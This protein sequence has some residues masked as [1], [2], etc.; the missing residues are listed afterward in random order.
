MRTGSPS[1]SSRSNH[2]VLQDNPSKAN[3]PHRLSQCLPFSKT[4]PSLVDRQSTQSNSRLLPNASTAANK[5]DAN[6][7][8]TPEWSSYYS[9]SSR[10]T[11]DKPSWLSLKQD[12]PVSVPKTP[13]QSRE[14]CTTLRGAATRLVKDVPTR[15]LMHSPANSGGTIRVNRDCNLESPTKWNMTTTQSPTVSSLQ[16]GD[17][18]PREATSSLLSV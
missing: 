6:I 16:K 10:E 8:R 9:T 3:V 4:F 7:E 15:R 14:D 17:D 1:P 5:D 11:R 18:S 2:V 13:V 12:Q